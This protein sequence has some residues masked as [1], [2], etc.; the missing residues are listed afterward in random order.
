MDT[1]TAE[2][3][4]QILSKNQCVAAHKLAKK[5]GV[6]YDTIRSWRKKFDIPY[7]KLNEDSKKKAFLIKHQ[8]LTNMEI[9]QM[10]GVSV[11]TIQRW[12]KKF[13]LPK[14]IDNKWGGTHDKRPVCFKQ[15]PYTSYK[16]PVEIIKDR[17]KWD[18]REFFYEM[19]VVRG[20]GTVLIGRMIQ[21]DRFV[22]RTKLKQYGIQTRSRVEAM[23]PK[24]P[25]CNRKWLEEN[26]EIQ[27]KTIGECAKIAGVNHY[28]I[29]NWLVRFGIPIRDK[30]E[31]SMGERNR[32]YG[33]RIPCLHG[34]PD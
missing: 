30:H 33:K 21:R 5:V 29:L 11:K 14:K 24:N 26:Y 17:K 3:I 4:R 22:V 19:Y 10:V 23:H 25:Y 34:R 16:I 12:R 6:H 31:C 20:Y 28:T 2:Q 9:G 18:N 32:Y 15:R 8:Y 7:M 13:N 1:Y 27:D